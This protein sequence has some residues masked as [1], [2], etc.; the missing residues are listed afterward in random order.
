MQPKESLRK[1]VVTGASGGI[2][3]AIVSALKSASYQPIGISHADADL[4]SHA[5]LEG[6][7]AAIKE[8]HRTVEWA[9]FSHGFIDAEKDF[10]REDDENI[11]ATVRINTLSLMYMTRLLLPHIEKGIIFISSTAGI[12][13]SGRHAVY[14]ASKAAVNAFSQALA[15]SL[16]AQTF[17]AICPGPTNTAMR[18]K[19]ADDADTSQ[20]PEV[21]AKVVARIALG[22]SPYKSGDIVIVRDGEDS[23]HAGL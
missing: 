12:F 1:I 15:K 17:I 23:R 11:E 5:A 18:R 7:C 13:P 8:T 9:I 4:S 14:S 22:T 2:G 3:S 20:S 21:V 10:L 19:V 16:P 6:I